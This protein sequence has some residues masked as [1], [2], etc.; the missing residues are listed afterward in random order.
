[1]MTEPRDRVDELQDMASDLPNGPAKVAFL[2]EAVHLADSL[3]DSDLA[4]SATN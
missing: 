4:F 3:N 1:M 2:E